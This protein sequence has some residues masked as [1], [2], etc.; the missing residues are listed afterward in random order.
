MLLSLALTAL[1][2]LDGPPPPPPERSEA[3]R[4]E[5]T[6]AVSSPEERLVAATKQ[7]PNE[8]TAWLDL[9]AY[10]LKEGR[11]LEAIEAL[12]QGVSLDPSSGV[13]LYNLAYAYR[14]V[15]R[16]KDAVATY[17][18]YLA[19]NPNDADAWYALAET[20]ER[21]QRW[22][23]AADAFDR[24]AATEERPTQQK[25][26]EQARKRATELRAKAA[27]SSTPDA[28]S[29]PAKTAAP[30]TKLDPAIAA[31]R[32]GEYRQALRRLRDDVPS[33]E[34]GFSL[35]AYG[36]A[37]L[38]EG[39]FRTAEAFFA[40]AAASLSGP[41]KAGALFGQA[42]ALF[43][44]GKVEEA[45]TLYRQVLEVDAVSPWADHARGRLGR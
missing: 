17:E 3:N 40:R 27:P 6:T 14:S 8:A 23:A 32:R 37:H 28:A 29:G 22:G 18:R 5:T 9:G 7:R 2:Q 41:G 15:G 1:V 21:L 33:P 25:W 31:L 11:A 45:R 39:D 24:Y 35:A 26:V 10:R 44:R 30:P 43:A 42:E 34:D 20:N 16:T 38:G 19:G 12:E 4:G 36:S 13:G